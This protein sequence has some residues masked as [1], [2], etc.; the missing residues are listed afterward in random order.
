MIDAAKTT[1]PGPTNP[2]RPWL[3][4][5]NDG[6]RAEVIFLGEPL[7]R[8]VCFVDGRSVPYDA[9]QAARGKRPSLRFS[10]CVALADTLEVKV[11]EQS[12]AFFRALARLR[13]MAPLDEHVFEVRRRGK[14]GDPR[15]TYSI[16]PVRRL[17]EETR[18]RVRDLM[19]ID[20][21]AIYTPLARVRPRELRRLADVG[22]RSLVERALAVL[23][24]ETQARFYEELGIESATELYAA[25]AEQ[26]LS[27]LERLEA[28]TARTLRAPD[29]DLVEAR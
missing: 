4:L 25:N 3:K 28:E 17:D 19:P 1:L 27:V 15:T 18:A 5:S 23:P 21:A 22:I 6:D 13:E 12:V 7:T 8:E 2:Y 20:L 26:A 9:E 11:M 14:A 10:F 24:R 16:S 29:L